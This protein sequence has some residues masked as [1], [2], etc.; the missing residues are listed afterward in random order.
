MVTAA[1][2]SRRLNKVNINVISSESVE[3]TKDDLLDMQKA[4]LLRGKG[5]DGNDLE[6]GY[7]EDPYFKSPESAMRYMEWKKKISPNVGRNDNAPNL[8]INGAFH[9]TVKVK[10]NTDSWDILSDSEIYN[11]VDQKYKGKEFGITPENKTAYAFGSFFQALK[12]R[13]EAITKLQLK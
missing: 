9:R 6:P 10:V 12:K 5:N 3:E 13:I 1:E 7:L 2:M 8:Y 4:Q 11:S